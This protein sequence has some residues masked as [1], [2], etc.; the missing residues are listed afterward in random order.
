MALDKEWG[1]RET[2]FLDVTWKLKEYLAAKP[3]FWLSL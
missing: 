2:A 1:K 3:R